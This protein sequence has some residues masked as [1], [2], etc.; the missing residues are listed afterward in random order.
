M[1]RAAL[2][3]LT[4]LGACSVFLGPDAPTDPRSL[5]ESLWRE[6]DRHY[7][8]FEHKGIDWDAQ[9]EAF[10]PPA[11]AS[12]ATL[13]N[14]ISS[15]L[16]VL[17]DPH[18]VVRT[19]LGNTQSGLAR[20][21]RSTFYSQTTALNYV[22]QL[23][24]TSGGQI[25]FG[26][27]S[28]RIGYARISNFG[29][30]GWGNAI[31]EALAQMPAIEALV[32]DA[33]N[34]GGGD[35]SNSADI[36]NRFADERRT[37]AYYRYRDGPERFDFSELRAIEIAPAG[38]RFTGPVVV[39]CNRRCA[40]ATEDFLLRMKVIPG[41]TLIGDTSMGAVGN[42]IQ[43]ELANGW[44]YQFSEW[45]LLTPE[46]DQVEDAGIAPAI[47]V[48]GTQADSLATVDRAL[49]RAITELNALLSVSAVRRTLSP[50]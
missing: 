28:A 7:S 40:S 4:L 16:N 24:L 26:T 27:L 32:I 10:M 21:R 14:R 20:A 41:V 33:R 15:L 5:Y 13:L 23:R 31:A 39:L 8:Y 34:N 19:P 36:A 50:P 42:P 11:D 12:E 22:S 18:V 48:Q 35:N 43:R 49:E 44:G 1:K 6:F 38:N 17:D 9:R 25:R 46:L 30:N 37:V 3:G 29:G 45:Q 47:V 2:A